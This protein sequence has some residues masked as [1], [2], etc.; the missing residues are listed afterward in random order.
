MNINNYD[1]KD[2]YLI[3]GR[4][5][6]DVSVKNKAKRADFDFVNL[7]NSKLSGRDC[8]KEHIQN[9]IDVLEEI[10]KLI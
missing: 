9:I 10:K 8:S 1:T 7:I 3:E 5:T 4:F 2:Y 6:A